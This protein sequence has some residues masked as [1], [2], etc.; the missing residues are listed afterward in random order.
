MNTWVKDEICV[1]FTSRVVGFGR[2]LELATTKVIYNAPFEIYCWFWFLAYILNF[3]DRHN[4]EFFKLIPTSL[5]FQTLR[6]NYGK[7]V[8]IVENFCD[9]F[10]LRQLFKVE[11][12]TEKGFHLIT[13]TEVW[14]DLLCSLSGHCYSMPEIVV[15]ELD[16]MGCHYFH[17]NGL[18]VGPI[19]LINHPCGCAISYGF[20]WQRLKKKKSRSSACRVTDIVP[21]YLSYDHARDSAYPSHVLKL[22]SEIVVKYFEPDDYL[23]FVNMNDWFAGMCKCSN[24]CSREGIRKEDCTILNVQQSS[25]PSQIF[26]L[27]QSS[28]STP[29]LIETN[30]I[31]LT[32][33]AYKAS[34]SKRF[35]TRAIKKTKALYS[36]KAKILGPTRQPKTKITI[37]HDQLKDPYDEWVGEYLMSHRAKKQCIR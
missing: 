12:N 20:D 5:L 29:N 2:Y 3:K 26:Y 14:F 18:L 28:L 21:V 7:F 22:D 23:S 6:S 34:I 19:A 30:G 8:D 16:Q 37:N 9:A 32:Q 36:K 17:D 24:C 10:F 35:K 4:K 33:L 15:N 1:G 13:K 25:L 31:H 11:Y 27:K